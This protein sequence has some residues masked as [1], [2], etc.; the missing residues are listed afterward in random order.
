MENPLDLFYKH[1]YER[2]TTSSYHIVISSVLRMNDSEREGTMTKL[3]MLFLKHLFGKPALPV[4]TAA[5]VLSMTISF[6]QPAP[7][8][9]GEI[10]MYKDKN[11]NTV[12]S[13]TPVPEKRQKKVKIIDGYKDTTPAEQQARQ[14]RDEKAKQSQRER[15]EKARQANQTQEDL[16]RKRMDDCIAATEK[17]YANAV[18]SH[19]RSRGLPDNCDLDARAT[20]FYK[21]QLEL[22]KAECNKK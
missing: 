7:V 5:A 12:L 2:D 20:V 10:Y 11:G 14:E 6:F 18:I 19:C 22:R 16:A 17:S 1:Q 8:S 13:N 3:R 4:F 15:D 9:G 21:N